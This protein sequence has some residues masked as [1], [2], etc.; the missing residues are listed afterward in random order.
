LDQPIRNTPV[1]AAPAVF[2]PSFVQDRGKNV[3]WQGFTRKSGLAGT[4]DSF[5]AIV[6]GVK[7]FLEPIKTALFEQRIFRGFWKAPGPWSL[8]P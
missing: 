4:P 2:D 5:T 6:A 7:V 8:V 3:Q 1:P